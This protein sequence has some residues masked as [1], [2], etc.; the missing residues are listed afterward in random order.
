M[1]G[2]LKDEVVEQNECSLQRLARAI[3]PSRGEFSLI[4]ACCNHEPLRQKVIQ[5]L[6][7]YPTF[8]LREIVLPPSAQTLYTTIKNA[9]GPDQPE[10]VMV[11]GLESVNALDRLLRGL[12]PERPLFRENFNFPVVLWVNDLLL[13]KMARQTPHFKSWGSVT[14]RFRATNTEVVVR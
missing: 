4:F 3:A 7:K 13:Q 8:K 10:A 11:S 5:Q 1:N 6:R 14:I 2:Q 12:D 9:L